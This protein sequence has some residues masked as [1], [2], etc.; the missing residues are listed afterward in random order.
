MNTEIFAKVNN[1]L[2]QQFNLSYSDS[3]TE[4]AMGLKSTSIEF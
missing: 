4:C 1:K 3:Y 2:L